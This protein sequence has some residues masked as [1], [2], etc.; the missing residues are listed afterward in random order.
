MDVKYVNPFIEAFH[1]VMP[2]LGFCDV[3]TGEMSA[4]TKEV[5]ATGVLV[6]VGIVGDVEGNVVYFTDIESAKKIASTMMMGAPVD[7]FDEMAE[8]ALSELTNMLTATATTVLASSGITA[9]IST[10][11]LLHGENVC[12]KMNAG[13]ILCVR[14]LA[15]NIPIEI[16]I[17]FGN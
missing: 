15:D 7:E 6:I 17:S 13:P 1:S 12:V 10:P 2:Q 5:A 3:Q 11:T 4:K 9:D 16:N 8:S 14:L